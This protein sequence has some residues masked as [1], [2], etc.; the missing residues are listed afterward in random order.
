MTNDRFP[1]KAGEHAERILQL[2][3]S[4]SGGDK[5]L[6]VSLWLSSINRNASFATTKKAENRTPIQVID[7]AWLP[8]DWTMLLESIRTIIQIPRSHI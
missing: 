7:A 1:Y 5:N 4:V 3:A 6:K 8:A 2:L